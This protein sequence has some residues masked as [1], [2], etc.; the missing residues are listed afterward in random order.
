[1][2]AGAGGAG[3][4][5]AQS[6]AGA[7]LGGTSLSPSCA[8]GDGAGSEA[9]GPS[10]DGAAQSS[11]AA[12][13]SARLGLVPLSDVSSAAERGARL[14]LAAAATVQHGTLSRAW[15]G[16]L[17]FT[18]AIVAFGEMAA[19]RGR[20]AGAL[21]V[22]AAS[23]AAGLDASA[24]EA[25]TRAMVWRQARLL[26][27]VQRGAPTVRDLSGSFRRWAVAAG[28]LRAV[29]AAGGADAAEWRARASQLLD[30]VRRAR[31][32]E[33]AASLQGT[34][35]AEAF[36]TRHVRANRIVAL[37]ERHRR[38]LPVMHAW[39]SWRTA[40]VLGQKAHVRARAR[41]CARAAARARARPRARRLV[42][43]WPL[44]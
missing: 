26:V 41:A 2:G 3:G 22:L 24:G 16:W 29:E 8:R 21:G 23:S 1:M 14:A 9:A 33:F 12:L 27:L 39:S 30:E 13:P 25:S 28:A 11:L 20:A 42:A 5:A 15:H 31:A 32:A 40:L 37:V 44:F 7:G 18:T 19:W 6:A 36:A 4:R 35:A 43:E 38:T 10:A 17:A 34:I